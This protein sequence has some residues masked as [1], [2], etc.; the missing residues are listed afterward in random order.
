MGAKL[1]ADEVQDEEFV[2]N[3]AAAVTA[4]HACVADGRRTP[5]TLR[6]PSRKRRLKAR[7]VWRPLD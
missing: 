3:C 7:W 6:A 1:P 4:G 5:S 2:P